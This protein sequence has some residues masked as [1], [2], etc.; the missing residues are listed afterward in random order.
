[1]RPN[2][3]QQ[4]ARYKIEVEQEWREKRRIREMEQDRAKAGGVYMGH[5]PGVGVPAAPDV[6]ADP[7]A[8][9]AK[10]KAM[11]EQGLIS[12]AEYDTLKAKVLSDF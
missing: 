8:K 12:E 5:V 11:L 1:M 4:M 2:F 7:V 3:E 6:A 10:A 9:L